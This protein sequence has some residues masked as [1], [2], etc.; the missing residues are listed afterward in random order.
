MSN[1][2]KTASANKGRVLRVKYGYN[3]NSSSIG[4]IVFAL[5]AA[6]L[7]ITAAFGAVA[8]AILAAIASDTL[9]AASVS[10]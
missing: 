1:S 7:G 10:A 5:P 2:Q 3:P 6:L 9:L 8:G 4:S